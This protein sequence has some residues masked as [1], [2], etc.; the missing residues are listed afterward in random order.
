MRIRELSFRNFRVFKDSPTF[1]FAERFTVVA[2]IN[3]RGKTSLLDGI[4]LLVSRFLPLVS[5]AR[6]SF[7]SM[8]PTEVHTGATFTELAMKVN[9]AGIPVEY[10]LF[11]ELER[12]KLTSSKL[13]TAV[14]QAVRKAYGDPNRA[15]DA[16]PLAV[17]Y[18]T[19]RAGYRPP[20]K[21]P[22]EV[23]RGQAAAYLGAL[24][25]RRVN[26]R[27]FMT[28]YRNAIV[29]E[30]EEKR[31]NPSYLG[32]R[33]ITAIS[34]AVATFLKGFENLRVQERPLRLLVDKNGVALDLSQLSD[35]ERSFLALICDLSRRLA[36]ANPQLVDPL[37]GLGVVLIDELELHMHPRWQREIS[38]K[39]RATFPNIQ[40]IATTHSPFVIQSL[41]PG[42]LIN[43]DPDEIKEYADKNI[44]EYADKSIEDIAENVMGVELP[45]KSERYQQMMIAAEEYFRLLRTPGTIVAGVDAAEQRLNELAAPFSDDPAFQALLKLERETQREGGGDAT[46]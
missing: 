5:P 8:S 12:R 35:G 20:K 22:D 13:S 15:D 2:G 27:D 17:Y 31:I 18:T 36:L 29:I 11:Y 4:A 32:D 6:S 23:P 9:C 19:D 25:N 41:R 37:S 38:E 45:Q 34:Q 28:R 43:L 42:E 39:L 3:G 26:Y 21:L 7:R 46:R 24:F 1:R 14:R 16:A 33:T 10:K 30:N 40:F 44:K